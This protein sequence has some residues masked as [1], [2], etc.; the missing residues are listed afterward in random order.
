MSTKSSR[1]RAVA[2]SPITRSSIKRVKQNEETIKV[3]EGVSMCSPNAVDVNI[4]ND[5]FFGSSCY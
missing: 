1:S 5:G 4:R 3:R 2:I